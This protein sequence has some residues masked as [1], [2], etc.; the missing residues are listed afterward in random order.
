MNRAGRRK[1]GGGDGDRDQRVDLERVLLGA[2]DK[3][4]G[5]AEVVLGVEKRVRGKG[6]GGGVIR[7]R[8]EETAERGERDTRPD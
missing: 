5:E 3:W 6:R 1:E 7:K 8:G 2:G 4:E